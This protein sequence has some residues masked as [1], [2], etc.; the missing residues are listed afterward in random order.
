MASSQLLIP[1]LDPAFSIDRE[2]PRGLD[3]PESLTDLSLVVT[4]L[5]AKIVVNKTL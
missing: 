5:E 3:L 2:A 4:G 1:V